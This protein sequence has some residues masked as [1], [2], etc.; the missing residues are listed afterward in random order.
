VR[1][2]H[3]Y[4]CAGPPT[5]FGRVT[6]EFHNSGHHAFTIASNAIAVHVASKYD[7]A[8][9]RQTP[10]PPFGMVVEAS[11]PMDDQNARALVIQRIIPN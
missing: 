4:P 2:Q 10:R 9:F 5:Q 7:E 1:N 3:L 11:A 6:A 8:E